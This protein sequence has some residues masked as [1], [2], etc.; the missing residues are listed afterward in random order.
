MT[1][2]SS[3]AA[4]ER[5]FAAEEIRELHSI[6]LF[7]VSG[8]TLHA[9]ILE[10]KG[11]VL[12][13]NGDFE[14]VKFS[15]E[16][17]IEFAVEYPLPYPAVA[18]YFWYWPRAERSAFLLRVDLAASRTEEE[19]YRFQI[20]F[21]GREKARLESVRTTIL[22]PKH[23]GLLENYPTQTALRRVQS[24]DT[25][26]IVALKG[27]TD[28]WRICDAAR[29][30]G[31][32][33]SGDVLD[34]GVG[35]GRVAR[36]IGRF[37][38]A[39]VS[40]IDIDADN[41]A[42]AA[43]QLPAL[44]VSVG[45]LMPPTSYADDQF[46]L[47]YGISVMTHLERSVQEA[48]L[49]EIKRILRP[50][51]IALLTFAGDAAVAFMSKGLDRDFLDT[52]LQTGFGPH[53]INNDLV[54]AIDT[55]EY[56]KD[57]MQTVGKAKEICSEFLTVIGAHRC[58]FGYQDL[59]VLRK[60]ARAGR[61]VP[62]ALRSPSAGAAQIPRLGS[63]ALEAPTTDDPTLPN[64]IRQALERN[65]N[66]SMRELRK[67]VGAVGPGFAQALRASGMK[68]GKRATTPFEPSDAAEPLSEELERRVRAELATNPD[69]EL[70]A[71]ASLL[72]VD[73][74]KLARSL[75][76]SGLTVKRGKKSQ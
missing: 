32:D 41:I 15:A 10:I 3:T 42:W 76:K 18:D 7:D 45:P 12:P 56:Y 67:E 4:V 57:V 63:E 69:I 66:L 14:T 44:S 23:L 11:F 8:F 20:S 21:A 59:L 16:P 26:N 28:A 24:F 72:G 74:R 19:H 68:V 51:G 65:P 53:Q 49:E 27:L 71:L 48:W 47:I 30:Y 22:V 73:R 38:E 37:S 29:S 52:Y 35:H 55:P 75:R 58:M 64:R 9:G 6:P 46:S 1:E 25:V 36:H 2:L 33:G 40:G 70:R 34:W 17:G 54:G 62:Q 31:W 43:R 60:P 13:V 50:G 39:S 5:P 61:R